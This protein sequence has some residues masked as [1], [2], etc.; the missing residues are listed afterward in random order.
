MRFQDLEDP[1]GSRPTPLEPLLPACLG[2]SPARPVLASAVS[3]A[4]AHDA[5]LSVDGAAS[6]VGRVALVSPPHRLRPAR[7]RLTAGAASARPGV[8]VVALQ[9]TSVPPGG[10]PAPEPVPGGPTGGRPRLLPHRHAGGVAPGGCQLG[11][12]R[13]RG[14]ARTHPP[15]RAPP[16]APRTL[17]PGRCAL[18]TLLHRTSARSPCPRG[19]R[20]RP[21]HRAVRRD[22]PRVLP[23]HRPRT[24]PQRLSPGE[25]A[26]RRRGDGLVRPPPVAQPGGPR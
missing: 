21:R 5:G 23:P 11:L 9:R 26:P 7:Q 3:R 4:A 15:S 20:K 13:N 24:I 18:R 19:H 25:K 8:R 17:A 16:A 1:H 14:G 12:F 6:L 10:T 22:L 2:K